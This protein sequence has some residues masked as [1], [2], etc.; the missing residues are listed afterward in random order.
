LPSGRP[1]RNNTAKPVEH[2]KA[3]QTSLTSQA[4]LLPAAAALVLGVV[5]GR[6]FQFFPYTTA[7][8]TAIII[9][10]L[11]LYRRP[12]RTTRYSAV[13]SILAG[14]SI[15]FLY[16]PGSVSPVEALNDKGTVRISGE[17]T[18]PPEERDGHTVVFL[19]PSL[20]HSPYSRAGMVRL[21]VKGTGLGIR[22]GDVLTCD[23]ELRTPRGLK[24][25]GTFEWGGYVMLNGIDSVAYASP[26]ALVRAGNRAGP[27]MGWLYSLRQGLI[28]CSRRSLPKPQAAIF[29]AMVLGDQGEVTDRMR[30]DFGASGT[31]HILSVS[32]SHIALFSALVFFLVKWAFFL[33][34]HGWA[35]RLTLMFDHRKL[36][37][38]IAVPAAVMYCLLA[39]SEPATVRSTI[40]VCAYLFSIIIERDGQVL[41]TLSA[42]AIIALVYEPSS[43]F[44][45]SFQLSY[46]AVF[47]MAISLS[48]FR[49]QSEEEPRQVSGPKKYGK[50]SASVLASV[51]AIVGTAP[52]AARQF[53]SF[54]YVA[55]P[56]NMLAV[57]VA[58]FVAVPLGLLSCLIYAI[59]PGTTLP[60][61]W[62]N[63]QVLGMFYGV[64]RLF[65]LAPHANVHPCAPGAI[66]TILFYVSMTAV[67]LWHTSAFRKT[68]A[69]GCSTAVF[70][71][72]VF[73]NPGH[74]E[75][76][77][78]T[79]FD[80][81]QGDSALVEFPGGQTMLID[82][83]GSVRGI[84]PGRSAIAPY[85]W[86]HG[87]RRLDY[88]V[89]TH[90]H[91]DHINGLAYIIDNF[92]VGQVW[93]GGLSSDN[94]GYARIC[95]LIKTLRLPRYVISGTGEMPVGGAT[96]QV[97]HTAA[98]SLDD[99]DREVYARENNRSLVLRVKY[100]DVSV[101]FAA[102]AGHEAQGA[103]L[104]ASPPL[105]L[106]STV[107]KMPHHGGRDACN[108]PFIRAVEPKAAVISVGRYNSFH[109]PSP[110]TVST[111]K[112]IGTRVLRTDMD[113]AVVFETNGKEF[114]LT[115]YED[116]SL[117][118][119]SGWD[120]E[121]A[122]W[123]RVFN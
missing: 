74:T 48:A 11:A 73:L 34:P 99:T 57:P 26:D 83:G 10:A 121:M 101:L 50:L 20:P 3:N 114:T 28:D 19:K 70:A 79:F 78:A 61:A 85:L 43:V 111:L 65:A 9:A 49:L 24:N 94:D 60:L 46:I 107:L 15:F 13:Y 96:M 77:T 40:M 93:E 39:G 64:V 90:P 98:E 14:I 42:A 33:L 97:L 95:K 116:A 31:T 104:A 35:L 17:V 108:E 38:S 81:G 103:M 100:R 109:H 1:S 82:G 18:S 62:L 5:I 110:E 23:M 32:G 56:A 4:P 123:K 54:S 58:G 22:Y 36:A 117:K 12:A 86:N 8:V 47:F 63:S 87:V 112:G 6:S 120:G 7:L 27:F 21:N 75:K 118:P 88:V 76:L 66:A 68:V 67:L 119:A 69:A 30:D 55:L 92:E 89:L 16:G 51:A 113:G 2:G 29:R 53:N 44:D 84:D 25:P 41:N 105:P 37:A 115:T 80:V 122:N 52:L 102:D 91:P 45:I 59:S 71:G 72:A 106:K